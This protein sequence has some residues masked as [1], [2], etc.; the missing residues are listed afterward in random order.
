MTT[1]TLLHSP[2]RRRAFRLLLLSE[3]RIAW[4]RP[5]G[6]VVAVGVPLALLIIFG[7]IPATTK[8]EAALG[9]ISFFE[10]YVPTLLVFVLIAVG[11][12]GLPQQLTTYR[13]QGVLRRLSTTPV[14][15]S[16]LL[17]AQ[18][19]VNVVLA[20]LALTLLLGVGVL[21]FGLSLPP[22]VTGKLLSLL[23]LTLTVAATLGLGLC[24]AALAASPQIANAAS[25]LLFYVLAF[26]SGLYV[27]L[28][29]IHSTVIHDISRALP[30]GA[31]FNALHA[32]FLGHSPG[33]EPLLVMAGWAVA[34][35][36]AASR[37][38][39]WE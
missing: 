39:R 32:S 10:L 24:T 7:S 26:F 11:V 29:S 1:L 20:V 18:M 3:M 6:L 33:A 13:A 16:W 12:G 22:T 2:H 17:A 31:G 14:S 37:L 25:G 15:P 28:Q 8:P 27:P 35:S 5:T 30:T 9:G 23:S 38:F 34:T 21:A 19:A 4:R 36:V